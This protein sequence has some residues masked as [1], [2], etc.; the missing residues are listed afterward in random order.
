MD[1]EDVGETVRFEVCGCCWHEESSWKNLDLNR[2]L[3]QVEERYTRNA[4]EA[5]LLDLKLLEVMEGQEYFSHKEPNTT[6][7]A[8]CEEA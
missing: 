6:K 5:E 8:V 7:I 3:D 1:V 4:K 2:V